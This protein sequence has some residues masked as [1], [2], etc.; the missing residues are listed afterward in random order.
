MHFAARTSRITASAI[1]EFFD[2]ARH[3][4]GAIDLSI[5]QGDFDI[6]E[7]IKQATA[8]ALESPTCGRYS[9]TEGYAELVTATTDH[10]RQAF[11]LPDGDRLMLTAGASGALTLAMLA[12]VDPGDE[13]LL[14]DPYFVSYRNLVHVAGGVP[15]FYDMYP[16][17]RLR[18]ERIAEQLGPR[19]RLVVLNSPANPTGAVWATDDLREVCRLCEKRGVP[20]LSD[21]LYALFALDTPHV[22]VKR[23]AGPDCLLVGGFSKSY[24]MAGWRL[25]WAAGPEALIDKMRT[26]Q[27]FTYVCPPTVLQRG[28]LAAF[29]VDMQAQV[30]AY[31]VKRD[32]MQQ[33]LEEAGYEVVRPAGSF[34]MFPKVPWGDDQTFCEA[35]LGHKLIVVPG[36]AFSRRNTHFRLSYAGDEAL[37]QGLEVLRRLAKPPK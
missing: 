12:L 31:R 36:G 15:V 22:S 32:F 13:V 2:K 16:D 20:I 21:E 5:G 25:G 18:P 1:R 8:R 35:A 34:F 33:G 28:A 19:T 11:G 4:P 26:L 10:V 29:A 17:F 30:E 3:I 6:P 23:F 14:P 9:A 7:P 24:G 37:K 27:Q